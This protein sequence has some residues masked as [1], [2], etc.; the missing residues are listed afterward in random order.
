MEL[1]VDKGVGVS[2][3]WTVAPK[4]EGSDR[5]ATVENRKRNDVQ[6]MC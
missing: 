3:F 2:L 5:A 4:A 1:Q 6:S